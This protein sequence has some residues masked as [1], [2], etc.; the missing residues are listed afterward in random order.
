MCF[1]NDHSLLIT[2]NLY[3][4]MLKTVFDISHSHPT[5]PVFTI[6]KPVITSFLLLGDPLQIIVCC[7]NDVHLE[8]STSD[9]ESVKLHDILK[10]TSVNSSGLS[11]LHINQVAR[12]APVTRQQYQTAQQSWPLTFHEDKQ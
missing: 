8:D 11:G 5:I 2:L 1:L 6:L 4:Q 3:H 9:L 12:V 7:K 10:N